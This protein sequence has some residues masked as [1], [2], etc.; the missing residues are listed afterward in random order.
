MFKI[1]KFNLV[2]KLINVYKTFK[3]WTRVVKG[4]QRPMGWTLFSKGWTFVLKLVIS[5]KLKDKF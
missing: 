5:Y 3:R 1:D 4:G 2:I